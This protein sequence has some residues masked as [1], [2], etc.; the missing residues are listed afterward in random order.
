MAWGD[1]KVTFTQWKETGRSGR[2]SQATDNL[3]IEVR[4]SCQAIAKLHPFAEIDRSSEQEQT[5]WQVRW[6]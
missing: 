4:T 1:I 3:G 5:I 2:S 6:R